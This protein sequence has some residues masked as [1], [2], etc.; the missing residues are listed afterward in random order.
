[1]GGLDDEDKL[2]Q[3]ENED[4]E[5]KKSGWRKVEK[6][7]WSK[8]KLNLDYSLFSAARSWL[9]FMGKTSPDSSK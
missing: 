7:T 1:M 9:T 4:V 8:N 5:K 3:I 2:L 6:A